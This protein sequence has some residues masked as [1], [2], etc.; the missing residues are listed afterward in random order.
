MSQV[1]TEGKKKHKEGK[2]KRKETELLHDVFLRGLEECLKTCR[3][4]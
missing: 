1:V 3:S 4:T 2:K